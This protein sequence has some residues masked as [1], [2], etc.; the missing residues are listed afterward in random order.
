VT[1][2]VTGMEQV[3]RR[4]AGE[5]VEWLQQKR[6]LAAKT[7]MRHLSSLSAF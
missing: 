6:G 4:V 7:T 3:T 2:K 1:L 5:F